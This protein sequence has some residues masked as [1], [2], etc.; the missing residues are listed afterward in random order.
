VNDASRLARS[1]LDV[2]SLVAVS[3]RSW[4]CFAAV[5]VLWGIP[6]LFIKLAV[7]ECPPLFVAWA[8][9]ALGAALLLPWAW[10]RGLLDG[11]RARWK[12]ALLWG[13]TEMAIPFPLVAF[14]EQRVSSSLTAILI[15]SAPLM[16][17]LFAEWLD[18]AERVRGARL[19][20]MAIGL[21]GVVALMGIDIGG[22]G[23]ELLG[24]G[25]ILLATA[26]YAVGPFTLR[27]PLGGADSVGAVALAMTFGAVALT[28]FAIAD[29]PS[30]TPSAT[31]LASLAVLG[32]FCSAAA[33]VLFAIL[34]RDVGGGRAMIITYVAPVV[35]VALG[36]SVLGESLG[37]GA[38]AGLL[39]I[40]A[41]SWLATGGRLIGRVRG[42]GRD[43]GG[44]PRAVPGAAP[45]L[46]PLVA[47]T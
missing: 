43:R 17:A 23:G 41:G 20:G 8:R 31:A 13:L 5:S 44:L 39:L 29:P 26:C 38:V 28:P 33:L 14:G 47:G 21:G 42:R 27:G 32:V 37:A 22:S 16:V 40:L 35:A 46:D 45:E 18:P 1:P 25:A 7:D 19:V 30:V 34:V 3:L 15:A 6:Y 24:A 36:V 11:L 12:W 10:R 2:D 9:V 4:S